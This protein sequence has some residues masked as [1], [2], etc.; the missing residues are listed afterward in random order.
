M[1]FWQGK[2]VFITGHTGFKGSWL[3]LLLKSL[4]A[5][6]TGLSLP[7]QGSLNLFTSAL[8]EQ[9]ITNIFGDVRDAVLVQSVMAKC[10][11][12]IIFHLAAQSL[13]RYSYRS[14]VETYSTNVM[15]TV[16]LLEAVRSVPSVKVVVNVTTDKCYE[17]HEQ[18]RGYVENDR[19]GGYDP[20]SNSKACSELVSNAYRDSYLRHNGVGLATVRAGNVIG[21]GDWAED[22]L[23]P[24]IVRSCMRDQPVLIR[25]PTSVRP[26]Q[27]VLDPLRGYLMLA[28]RLY[29]QAAVFAKGWNFGPHMSEIKPVSWIADRLVSRLNKKNGWKVEEGQH[30]HEASLLILDC[31]QARELLAWKPRYTL[32]QGLEE[33]ISWYEAYIAGKDMRQFTLE[34]INRFL[35]FH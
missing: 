32:E 20:Y 22:R 11:P 12:E 18:S 27:Y 24:D 28:E 6:L 5:E 35:F 21:G 29:H 10:Q 16:H 9:D 30:L 17:N 3:V 33:T 15:G 2:K 4:G 1:T 8:V 26:W 34:Q 23:I 19:L 25:Y 31:L 7:P 13:V 14:P